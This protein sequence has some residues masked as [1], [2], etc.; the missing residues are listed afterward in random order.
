MAFYI[1]AQSTELYA[2]W[3]LLESVKHPERADEVFTRYRQRIDPASLTLVMIE[4]P[5][6]FE[7]RRQIQA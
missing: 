1:F 5:D 6:V 3:V 7:A 2:E 4:A